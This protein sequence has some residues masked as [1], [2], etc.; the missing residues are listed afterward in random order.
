[1]KLKSTAKETVNWM[2][3]SLLKTK[4]KTKTFLTVHQTGDWHLEYT[5]NLNIYNIYNQEYKQSN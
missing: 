1:M 3:I 2:K 4:T 5:R